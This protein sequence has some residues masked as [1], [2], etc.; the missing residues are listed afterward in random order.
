MITGTIYDL[1]TG[2]I[3]WHV[4][5]LEEDVQRQTL[6]GYGVITEKIDDT[7]HYIDAQTETALARPTF[8]LSHPSTVLADMIAEATITGIP[9]GTKVTWP[10]GVIT[11][12]TD[13]QVELST[14]TPGFYTFRFELW[15][16]QDKEIT[17]EAVADL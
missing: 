5:A 3:M 2:E 16:Y 13:G 7:T 12:E 1:T 17:I 11:T 9:S 10:D 14:D 4:T 8:S 6:L 15:P